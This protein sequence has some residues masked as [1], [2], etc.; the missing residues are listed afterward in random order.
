MTAF[1]DNS[2]S[3]PN[4]PNNPP[5]LVTW[6][7]QTTDEMCLAYVSYI[8]DKKGNRNEAVSQMVDEIALDPVAN[9]VIKMNGK[10]MLETA[11]IRMFSGLLSSSPTEM[12]N[13]SNGYT[14]K[15]MNLLPWHKVDP[16][17]PGVLNQVKPACH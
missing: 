9:P 17:M 14:R 2:T 6:G 4:Q 3:N 15:D 10:D 13:W 7:E 8:L 16:S 12:Y 1:Y 11:R 5:K